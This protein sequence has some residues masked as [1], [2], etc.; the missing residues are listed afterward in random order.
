MSSFVPYKI[1]DGSS[2]IVYR[3]S[4]NQAVKC[5]RAGQ[6]HEIEHER[7]VLER[8]GEHPAIIQSF[9]KQHEGE[10]ILE[11]H[12]HNLQDI[13]ASDDAIPRWEWAIQIAE[14]VAYLHPRGVIYRDLNPCNVL[15]TATKDVVLCDF[16]ASS[17][18]GNWVPE[19]GIDIRY[20]RPN[21]SGAVSPKD[22]LFA[23]GSVLY[24]L[25]THTTPYA[26]KEDGEV[27][28]LYQ[29]NIFPMVDH[30]P[31]GDI[32]TKCWTGS[33]NS[34]TQLLYDLVSLFSLHFYRKA[35]LLIRN[36]IA[37]SVAGPLSDGLRGCLII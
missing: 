28:A 15:V 4:P 2:S 1:G 17:L 30:L 29:S 21:D 25:F 37:C 24:G 5:A 36:K 16:A 10:I 34:A 14:G 8:L 19:C 3:S 32:I 13:L 23:L 20:C 9:G 35:N 12:R 11:Y 31:I 18:D 27:L 33:Y 7:K 6:S 22:D 26:E